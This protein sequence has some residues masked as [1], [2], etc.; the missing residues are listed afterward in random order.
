MKIWS[1][2]VIWTFS[3]AR[4]WLCCAPVYGL[5]KH[6]VKQ[7]VYPFKHAFKQ[8]QCELFKPIFLQDTIFSSEGQSFVFYTKLWKS[9]TIYNGRTM[10]MAVM[11]MASAG[12]FSGVRFHLRRCPQGVA[13]V[14]CKKIPHFRVPTIK[15][16]PP[17]GTWH[18]RQ[19]PLECGNDYYIKYVVELFSSTISSRLPNNGALWFSVTNSGNP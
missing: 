2:K 5:T 14:H 15:V 18:A 10:V 1:F 4:S 11:N 16:R 6:V 17:N 19:P 9:S 8:D 13:S 12:G 3:G 7:N